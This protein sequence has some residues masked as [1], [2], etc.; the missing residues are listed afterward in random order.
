MTRNNPRH[1]SR[2]RTPQA[3]RLVAA[4][5]ILAATN[6]GCTP[7]SQEK[8]MTEYREN[9]NPTKAYRLTMR[10]DDAPGPLQ[11][12]VSAS[13]FDVVN[14]ECLPPP[15]SNPGGH[16]S[17]IPTNDIPFQLERV[18][19]NEYTGIVYADGMIDE[20]YY[21]RG[22]CRW[23]L[24]NVQVQ[25]KAT[26][27]KEETKFMADLYG[28]EFFAAQVKTIYF[29]KELYPR[30]PDSQLDEPKNSGQTDRAKI[31]SFRDDELFTI[32]L[33]SKELTP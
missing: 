12:M 2:R 27:A 13:Q 19:D 20:D 24:I 25:L 16:L 32:T 21:G 31:S 7:A 6:A 3:K 28:D 22:V 17:P 33:A 14:R 1:P 4:L 11:V 23:K 8:P 18:S 26:G 9:P 15:D 30:H 10:I 29:R 5:A